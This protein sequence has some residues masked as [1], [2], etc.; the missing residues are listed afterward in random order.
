MDF[1][2]PCVFA[3]GAAHVDVFDLR[4]LF[5]DTLENR[6]GFEPTR[7]DFFSLASPYPNPFNS[8]TRIGFTVGAQGLAP[9]RLCVFDPLGRRVAELW[10]GHPPLVPPASGGGKY[11]VVWDAAGVPA[12]EYLIRLQAGEETEVARVQV[13]R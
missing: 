8:T 9:L 7:P 5:G 10:N 2:N 11:S 12:G 13:V 3:A 6:S 4:P 1:A